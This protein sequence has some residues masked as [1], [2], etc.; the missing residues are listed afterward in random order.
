M[1]YISN[2]DVHQQIKNRIQVLSKLP[3]LIPCCDATNV[4]STK[5]RGAL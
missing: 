2:T 5:V 1:R 4:M 3:V